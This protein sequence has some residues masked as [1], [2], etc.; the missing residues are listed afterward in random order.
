[1]DQI[2]AYQSLAST[3]AILSFPP[4]CIASICLP[5]ILIIQL[6]SSLVIRRCKTPS[7]D[8]VTKAMRGSSFRC[9]RCFIALVPL[10]SPQCFEFQW[11]FSS[12]GNIKLHGSMI[13]CV[14][15]SCLQ[16]WKPGVGYCHLIKIRP[17]LISR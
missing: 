9:L 4:S 15:S 8:G 2:Q 10:I 5:L 17:A 6:M 14:C 1:M 3:A 12:R 11:L 13:R 16:G 7:Q